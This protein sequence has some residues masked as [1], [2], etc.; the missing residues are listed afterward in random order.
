MIKKKKAAN[1]NGTVAAGPHTVGYG[2][3]PKHA[4]FQRGKSGN[5]K[6]RPKGSPDLAALLKASFGQQLTA[7]V[8]GKSKK[9]PVIEALIRKNLAMALS[10]KPGAMKLA[11]EHYN[12]AFP[13]SNNNEPP[14]AGSSFDLTPEQLAAVEKS[15]LLRGIK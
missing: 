5:P 6:G 12:V 2:K 4:Q 15:N 14:S 7:N 9:M 8:D 11:L 3:P 1:D 10:G 13:P